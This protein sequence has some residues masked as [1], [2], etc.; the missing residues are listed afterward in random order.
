MRDIAREAGVSQGAVSLALGGKPGVSE[1]TRSRVQAIARRLGYRPDARL[2]VLSE[3]RWHARSEAGGDRLAVLESSAMEQTHAEV[4][5]A[6]RERARMLGYGLEV[7]RLDPE[8]RPEQ[9]ERILRARGIRGAILM[10]GILRGALIDWR[11]QE[12]ALVD[13]SVFSRD[14]RYHAVVM[15]HL[16]SAQRLIQ[17]LGSHDFRRVVF[18]T[19]EDRGT[20]TD[21]L[22]AAAIGLLR[23]NLGRRCVAAPVF[24]SKGGPEDGF[25][26]WVQRKSPDLVIGMNDLFAHRLRK[27]LVS[28]SGLSVVSMNCRGGWVSGFVRENEEIGRRA[29]ELLA[30]SLARQEFGEPSCQNVVHVSCR[31]H[32]GGTLRG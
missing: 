16:H 20:F 3:R 17:L 29:V 5:T 22:R 12:L 13:C 8:T 21:L 26:A 19:F 10:E 28:E 23:E 4:V 11:P 18:G 25:D 7:F 1:K 15:D 14:R 6:M 9:V 32:A 31:W 27:E 30:T 2:A 24:R